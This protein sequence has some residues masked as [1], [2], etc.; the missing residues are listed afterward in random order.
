M[1]GMSAGG[2][3]GA[4]GAGGAGGTAPQ[5]PPSLACLLEPGDKP[6]S[7]WSVW[8]GDKSL[9]PNNAGVPYFEYMPDG[10]FSALKEENGQ[11]AF[12][13]SEFENFRTLGPSPFPEAQ[14]TLSPAGKVAGG[15]GG[16]LGWDNWGKWL[17]SVFREDKSK[18]IGFYH[19]EDTTVGG[20]WKSM[21]VAYSSD[22][23]QSWSAGE[24]VVAAAGAK[25]QGVEGGNGD[26]SVIY[27]ECN[28]R[29]VMFFEH[30]YLT[31]AVSSDPRAAAGTWKKFYQGAFSEPGVGGL[32]S[33][34]PS[35]L[36][37]PGQTP[38]VHFNSY[39]EKWVMVWGGWDP[40]HIFISS[41][42]DL[43]EWSTPLDIVAPEG[44]AIR[45][46]YPTIISDQGDTVAG[47][48]ATLYY[49]EMFPGTGNRSFLKRTIT[50]TRND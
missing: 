28:Q 34:L 38:A 7:D 3:A 48:S 30:S 32:D 5:L 37:A 43:L 35:L 12:Y 45:A 15:R 47:K 4:S 39:L 11:W 26:G 50:F 49:A 27:D 9:V 41:S 40:L 23:G 14:T 17:V 16:Q 24:Q 18:L 8:L 44:S 22:N 46:W 29:W 42:T 21:A 33:P 1:A 25:P 19:A 36:P 10:H 20:D 31:A 6:S 13:W 2:A